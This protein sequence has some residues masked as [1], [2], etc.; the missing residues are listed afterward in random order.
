MNQELR[1]MQPHIIFN[2]RNGLPGDFGTPENHITAPVPWRPWEA[3]MTLNNHWGFHRSD[4]NWKSPIE[5]VNML[6]KCA[7]GQGNLLLNIGP[8]GTGAIPEES[9]RIVRTVGKWIRSGGDELLQP[10]LEKL[11]FAPCL[12]EKGDRGD[13][14]PAGP[15]FARGNVLYQIMFFQPGKRH[16]LTGLECEV[17]AVSAK[18]FGQLRF[19]QS[20]GRL[21]IELPDGFADAFAP[22][23]RIECRQPP[24]I[25]RTG[26]LRVPEC[27]HP[28][29]DPVQPDI[30]YNA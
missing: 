7:L 2:G 23:L 6:M 3:C 15:F 20:G 25:Y 14:D 26:G 5:V 13:W 9:R 27:Q 18:C 10:G 29:Y 17:N 24:S 28:R 12:R 22:V 16:V 19:R 1:E 21:E 11:S 4:N 30:D 8:D